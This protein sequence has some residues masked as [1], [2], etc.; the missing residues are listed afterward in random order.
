[1]V[2]QYNPYRANYLLLK[3]RPDQFRQTLQF[4]E[5]DI[6]LLSP[7]SVF[8]YTFI[9]EKL[10]R[11]YESENRMSTVFKVFA[12]F[13]LFIS[14]LGLLGLS[15]YSARIRIKE[16]GIRK[17]LGASISNVTL[18]LSRDFLK[19]VLLATLI[20]WPLGWWAMSYWLNGFAYH[21]GIGAGVFVISGMLAFLVGLL[22][23]SSQAVKA[24]VGNPV[25]SLRSE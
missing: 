5:S 9:D 14:C 11:L 2:I 8:S 16:V 17:L 20:A 18:L 13:A 6:K 23:V 3:V 24:A 21:I 7:A 19:L 22:T 1:M 25:D 12:G 10:N 15:A 4:L